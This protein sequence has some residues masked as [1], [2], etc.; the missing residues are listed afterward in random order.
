MENIKALHR[1]EINKADQSSS[2]GLI[3]R[4]KEPNLQHYPSGT[5]RIVTVRNPSERPPRPTDG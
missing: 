1:G 3:I 4:Q 5:P 2:I